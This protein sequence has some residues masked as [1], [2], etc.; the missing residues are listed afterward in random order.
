VEREQ[1]IGRPVH[2]SGGMAVKALK[3]YD[4]PRDLYHVVH[5]LRIVGPTESATF[6]I[7]DDVGCIIDVT[8]VYQYLAARAQAAGA[9]IRT[10]T[11]ARVLKTDQ[12]ILGARLHGTDG[13]TEQRARMVMDTTGYRAALSK[14]SGLHPGF[15]RFGVGAEYEVLAPDY[16]QDEMVI[17]VGSRFAP[18]G[19]AWAFPWGANRVRVGVGLIHSD[20]RD[21]PSDYLD[22]L[23]K[24]SDDIGIN[25]LG[26]QIV[27]EHRGLIPSETLPSTFV[28]D[29][30][31]A[32]GDAAAQPTLVAGEGI[33]LSLAAGTRAGRV[34]VEALAAG[35]PTR[36]ALLPYEQWFR[37]TYGFSLKMSYRVN[38][39][40]A[41]WDDPEWDEKVRLC[42]TVSGND[43]AE[44]LQANY[45]TWAGA[46]WLAR[47]P[48][49]WGL[50]ARYGL[51]AAARLLAG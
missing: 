36:D 42:R 10:G 41:S 4:V 18:K 28:G 32:V 25:L 2:T 15:R 37:K 12:R 1:E 3:E 38:R 34:A 47:H 22:R 43:M 27:E 20:T 44:L 29:R 45:G 14:Q 6:K 35:E 17:V 33:R 49:Y 46:R 13:V 9:E 48:R 21:D 30:I 11:T 7:D 16:D 51:G 39:R 50:A 19:Y 23:M 40:M 8:G 26:A 31:L 5:T 24:E